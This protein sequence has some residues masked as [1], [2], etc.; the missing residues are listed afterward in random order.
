MNFRKK[1]GKIKVQEKNVL[2]RIVD[3]VDEANRLEELEA[4]RKAE[5]KSP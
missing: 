3:A 5:G 2:D 4:K 1:A